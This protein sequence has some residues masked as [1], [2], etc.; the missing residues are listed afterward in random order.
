MTQSV[1]CPRCLVAVAVSDDAGGT[2]VVC[3]HC[4]ETFLVPGVSASTTNDD[5][6]WLVLSDPPEK[7]AVKPQDATITPTKISRSTPPQPSA[8][9]PATQSNADSDEPPTSAAEGDLFGMDLPPVDSG[10]ESEDADPFGFDNIQDLSDGS[11]A[12]GT[13]KAA[14]AFDDPDDPF[15]FDA[16]EESVTSSAGVAPVAPASKDSTVDPLFE[17]AAALAAAASK[18]KPPSSDKPVAHNVEYEEHYRV[19]CPVCA[20]MMN[21]TAAQAGKQVRCHDCH[22]MIKVPPAPRKKKKV[23]IDMERAQSFQFNESSVT[24]SDRPA[25]PFRK[26]AQELL[27]QAARTEEDS[28]AAD[29]DVPKISDWAKSVFGIFSQ[30]SVTVHWLILSTIGSA[31]AGIA[32]A[33]GF[34]AALKFLFPAGI[35]YGAMVL[36]CGFTILQSVSNDEDEVSDWPLTLEPLEWL[37]P[38]L[39]CFAAVGLTGGPGWMIGTLA[40]GQNLATV[41]LIML[42]VFLL[43][44]F[45]LLSMLDMQNMF[46][47]FSPE[48]GRSVTRCEEA[49]GGF[50]LSAALIFFAAFLIFVSAS[51]M[52]PIA[53]AAVCIFT[54]TAGTFI[55][56]AM[57]GRLAKAIGQAVND[58]P[59]ENDIEE[60]RE[61]DREK[62]RAREAGG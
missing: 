42:S 4:R 11:T 43:F 8:T 36:A 31:V 44:P 62:D 39:F 27:D 30:L 58:K 61:K 54:G 6:D 33:T 25:D 35:V 23:V 7:P 9:G 22:K 26:S 21:V 38:T 56:F 53:A 17:Q 34:D 45:V 37:A 55:Y 57:L 59:R 49:W 40:F 16:M 50:Y 18:P 2:R 19:R 10:P 13:T 12:A 1:Q 28:P 41:C 20:T 47:P 3:P 5:D 52:S 24:Q 46:V 48:V 14:D 15:N 29:L 60:V 51:L 32:I